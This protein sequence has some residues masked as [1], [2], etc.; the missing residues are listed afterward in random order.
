MEIETFQQAGLLQS[1]PQSSRWLRKTRPLLCL[2]VQIY[3][4][5]IV[6]CIFITRVRY[7]SHQAEQRMRISRKRTYRPTRLLLTHLLTYLLTH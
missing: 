5:L 7:C 2:C 4:V 3:V 1:L 6:G